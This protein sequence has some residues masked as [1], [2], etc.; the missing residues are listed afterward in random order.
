MFEGD[1]GPLFDPIYGIT[2]NSMESEPSAEQTSRVIRRGIDSRLVGLKEGSHAQ[3]WLG[4]SGSV[5]TWHS[6]IYR[7]RDAE[8]VS[9]DD[10]IELYLK[11]KEST[12][13]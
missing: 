5:I 4:Q 11:D 10:G 8:R 3:S 13:E 6:R 1:V 2:S 12:F 7:P 9:V